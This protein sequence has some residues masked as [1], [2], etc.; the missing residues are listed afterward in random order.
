MYKGVFMLHWFKFLAL[1]ICQIKKP[2]AVCCVEDYDSKRF[3]FYISTNPEDKMAKL[4]KKL[5]KMQRKIL[6]SLPR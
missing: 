5:W 6:K 3:F 2:T 4:E 1:R